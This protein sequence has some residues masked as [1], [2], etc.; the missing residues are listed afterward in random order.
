MSWVSIEK[1]IPRSAKVIPIW[2][3]EN[4]NDYRNDLVYLT[5][6][7]KYFVSVDHKR[8]YPVNSSIVWNML[9]IPI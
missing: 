9:D 1:H 8:V 2:I 4:I 7:E 6:D 3:K 5:D